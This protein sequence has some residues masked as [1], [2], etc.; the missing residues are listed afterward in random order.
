[1]IVSY[2]R[3]VLVGR[4]WQYCIIDCRPLASP[5]GGYTRPDISGQRRPDSNGLCTHNLVCADFGQQSVNCNDISR[6]WILPH[7]GFLTQSLQE[8]CLLTAC[9]VSNR[10]RIVYRL[11]WKLDHV[12][13]H[14]DRWFWSATYRLKNEKECKKE[15]SVYVNRTDRCSMALLTNRTITIDYASSV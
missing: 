14:I 2:H 1:M 15:E 7:I 4:S 9:F 12:W 11:L 3:G 13:I 5:S 6:P 10:F 8:P